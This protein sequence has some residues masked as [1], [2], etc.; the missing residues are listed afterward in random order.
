MDN[1]GD[2][3]TF[4]LCGSACDSIGY[5]YFAY[6]ARMCFCGNEISTITRYGLYTESTRNNI[7]RSNCVKTRHFIMN[8]KWTMAIYKWTPSST[9]LVDPSGLSKYFFSANHSSIYIDTQHQL[10][11]ED[12]K[13]VPILQ[14]PVMMMN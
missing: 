10:H 8:G 6:D 3:Q 1:I 9:V 4:D 12:G 13:L 5:E 11:V 2:Y 14:V 7:T